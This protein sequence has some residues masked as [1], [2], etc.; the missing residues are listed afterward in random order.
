MFVPILTL[1]ILLGFISLVAVPSHFVLVKSQKTS[2]IVKRL[3]KFS[4]GATAASGFGLVLL[5]ASITYTCL[6][7]AIYLVVVIPIMKQAESTAKRLSI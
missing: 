1:H 3:A 2:R 7:M 5:G 4:V 6:S